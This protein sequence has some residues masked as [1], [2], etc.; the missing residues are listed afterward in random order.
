MNPITA[1]AREDALELF[2]KYNKSESLFKHALSVE[3]VNAN[4]VQ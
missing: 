3:A 2:R 1:P 4:D